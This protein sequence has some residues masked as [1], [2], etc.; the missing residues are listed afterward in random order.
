MF[1]VLKFSMF[2][3]S[4]LAKLITFECSNSYCWHSRIGSLGRKEDT[5]FV[6][7]LAITEITSYFSGGLLLETMTV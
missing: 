2:H 7:P 4:V 3:K 1:Y 6:S 5:Q